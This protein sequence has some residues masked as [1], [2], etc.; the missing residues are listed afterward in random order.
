MTWAYSWGAIWQWGCHLL[1]LTF[2]FLANLGPI[3]V[4]CVSVYITRRGKI[5]TYTFPWKQLFIITRNM[6]TVF[7]SIYL[8]LPLGF[9]CLPSCRSRN[10][11]VS[12]ICESCQDRLSGLKHH[13]HL[14]GLTACA[15]WIWNFIS[16]EIKWSILLH[17]DKMAIRCQFG[18][19]HIQTIG[20]KQALYFQRQAFSVM[21]KILD[22]GC[23][24]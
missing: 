21:P 3:W 7:F 8:L 10:N 14:K 6:K 15:L 13:N 19:S 5:N 16:Q 9:I 1:I 17:V 24:E 23:L 11:L 2:L 20:N 18:E 12:E 4:L 22:K